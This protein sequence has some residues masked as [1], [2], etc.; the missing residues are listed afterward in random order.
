LWLSG[1][2]FLRLLQLR[3]LLGCLLGR[4]LRGSLLWCHLLLLLRNG[5]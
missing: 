3:C 2:H 5:L 1:R 4:L